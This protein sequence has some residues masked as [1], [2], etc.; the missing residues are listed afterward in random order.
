[1]GRRFQER[2]KTIGMDC[3][4]TASHALPET[5]GIEEARPE[6]DRRVGRSEGSSI[7]HRPR[8]PV[9]RPGADADC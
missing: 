2:L 6:I 8:G 7:I 5:W 3:G 4:V 9:H 1:M